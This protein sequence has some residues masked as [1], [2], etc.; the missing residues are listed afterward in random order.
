MT[1][2]RRGVYAGGGP[3]DGLRILLSGS[4]ED[5]CGVLGKVIS[6]M[7]VPGRSVLSPEM[8]YLSFLTLNKWIRRFLF[9]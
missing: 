8:Q 5:G 9:H 2:P 1:P 7:G 3:E 4:K 6:V